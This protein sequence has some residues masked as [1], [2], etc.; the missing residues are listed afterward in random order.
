VLRGLVRAAFGRRRKTLGNQLSD[1]LKGERDEIQ[2][3]LRSQDVDPQ[4]RGETLSVDEFVKLARAARDQ[5]A[6]ATG[7]QQLSTAH[8]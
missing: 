3:F 7:D 1:W 5:S 6:L 4:R 8:R 2:E